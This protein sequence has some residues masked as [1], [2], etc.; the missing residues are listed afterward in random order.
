MT[1][2]E[3]F[4]FGSRADDWPIQCYRWPTDADHRGTD[5]IAHG[6]PDSDPPFHPKQS[7][8]VR[9]GVFVCGDHRDTPSIQ[10][11]LYSGRRVAESI[12]ANLP[13]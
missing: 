1:I 9:N 5:V 10:G 11:A 8:R 3:A 7:V 4:C 2:P 6:Q 12:L 13:S